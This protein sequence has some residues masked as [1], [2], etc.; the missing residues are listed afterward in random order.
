MLAVEYL[1]YLHSRKIFR[2]EDVDIRCTVTYTAVRAARKFSEYQ[3]KENY[4]GNK[5]D[6]HKR[7]H[8]VYKCHSD[9]Y[10]EDY[11]EILYKIYK[12]IRKGSR[13]C[14]G[15]VCNTGYERTDGDFVQLIV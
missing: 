14:I 10:S 15:V 3:R 11:K 7:E 4:E 2:K 1:N 12:N 9:E 8:I 13:Y 6:Y 5:A